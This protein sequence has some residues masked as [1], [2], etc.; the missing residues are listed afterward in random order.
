MS[1]LG[2]LREI[3]EDEVGTMLGWR[4]SPDI[5]KNMYTQHEISS[6]EHLAWWR[7]VQR[8]DDQK[9]FMYA[10]N[11]SPM[12][13]VAFN[14][15][16]SVNEHSF[17]AFYASPEAP[18]GTGTKMELNALN[19]AFDILDLHKLS[20][21]VLAYNEP[22]I[23]LHK[24]FG[25]QVEGIFKDHH[26]ASDKYGDVYRLGILKEEWLILKPDIQTRILKFS[27]R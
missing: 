9:Y 23:K 10:L 12:G 21:E 15:I 8:R 7:G 19:Y 16:D 1:Q 3:R 17:W 25:F 14:N 11:G 20:C 4:N 2:E 24:K 5:R 18:R 13:I 6:E 26:K 27:Q 22:V